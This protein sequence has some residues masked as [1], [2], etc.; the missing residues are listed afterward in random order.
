MRIKNWFLLVLLSVAGTVQAQMLMTKLPVDSAVRIGKL[1]NGLTYYIRYNNWPEHRANFYIAQKVG[2]IQEEENQR[3]LAHFLEHMCF[4]GTKHFPGDALLRYCESLGVKFGVDLN[5]YT[6]IDQTV[7]NIDNVPTARQ[8]ALDSCL[9]ILRDWAG[10]LTLDPKEIDQERG[11]IHEEW[12]LRTSARSRMFERNLPKLYPGS[13]YGVRYPIG[14]MS[15]VDNFKYKE[16]R[17]YY[18]KWYHPNNQG[19]IVVG[20]VDVDHVEAE[21]K[22][23]FGDLKNPLNALPVVDEQVPDNHAPIVIID[24]DKEER[25]SIVQLMIKHEAT[26]DSVKGNLKYLIYLYIKEVGIGLLNERLNEVAQK[27][28]C[29]FVGAG[30]SDGNYIFA[31][32]KDAFT[33]AAV[34]K[35]ISLTAAALKAVYEEA[36]RAAEFGFT[37]TEYNRSK[38][39]TLSSLDKM[40]SN[41]DKRF[42][43]Q[44]A[45]EYKDH[46]LS[47]EPIPSLEY[48]YQML[49]QIV[50]NV[51]IEYVNEV[52]KSLVSK[53]DT[54]L[55]IINFNPEKEGSVYPTETQLL[56]AVKEARTEKLAPYV[57]NVK[58]EPLMSKLPKPGKIKSEK[59]NEKFDFTEI[60]LSNGV[61]VLLKKTDFKKDQVTLNGN[62]GGGSSFYGEKDFINLEVFDNV[63]NISGLGNFSNTELTKAMAGKIATAS[64]TMGDKRMQVSGSSTPKDME[65]MLQLVYLHFTK[66]AKDQKSFDAMIESLKINLK[67]RSASPDIAYQ[68]SVTATMYG[69]NK[70][71]KPM[72]L[73]DLPAINY[74]RI[75]QMAAERTANANGWRFTIIGN[76]DENT[77]RPLICRYLGSLPSKGKNV[78][79]KRVLNLQKGIVNNDFT[80]KMETPKANATMVW[81]N[82]DMPYTTETAIKANIAGQILSM[83]YLKKIREEASAAYSCGAAGSA[84]ID[85]DYHNVTIYAYCPMKPEKSTEALQIMHDEMQNLATTCDASMLAKVKEYMLKEADDAVKTNGY[86]VNVIGT[87]YRYGIDSHTDYKALVAAQTPE[88]ISSFVKDF[89]KAGNRIQVTMM[90]EK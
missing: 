48:S 41:R 82:E 88:S 10:S 74:D 78:K 24:K 80:R 69:H 35:D 72:E 56:T 25:S 31:K 19:I 26:P 67:N 32:T 65:A 36:L 1:K 18:E 60:K 71:V 57:D 49:K 50:P 22:R 70:R 55:V 9:L 6:S 3:G 58:N 40:Y 47:N 85:D 52:F 16:L 4:N 14:L 12:R 11:V 66:I 38:I 5:A 86:W 75:L 37:E 29:P 79:G 59:R 42:T 34:P 89:L 46:F 20:D 15:V 45:S 87:F 63:I 8:S 73:S 76:Y 28:D 23:L 7:Y 64:L 84:T 77:I 17:D 61:T 54:N 62:G 30:T 83:V 44:F 68:D 53:S 2:S 33:I 90:P 51:P 43:E 21:I 27:P 13:K 81:F 39:N